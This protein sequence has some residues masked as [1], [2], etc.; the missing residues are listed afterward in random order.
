MVGEIVK[1]DINFA[2]SHAMELHDIVA[3][4]NADEIL[5]RMSTED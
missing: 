3:Q 1:I 2:K 4:K 5:N